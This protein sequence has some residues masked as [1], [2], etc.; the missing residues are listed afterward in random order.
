MDGLRQRLMMTTPLLLSTATR[1]HHATRHSPGNTLHVVAGRRS[2]TTAERVP[3]AICLNPGLVFY[4]WLRSIDHLA[5]TWTFQPELDKASLSHQVPTTA[6]YGSLISHD[7]AADSS[8]RYYPDIIGGGGDTISSFADMIADYSTDDLFE[9]AWEQG[10][11]GGSGGASGSTTAAAAMM[12]QPAASHLWSPPAPPWSDDYPPSESEMAAWLRAIVNGEELA[13]DD[14]LKTTV[15]G[16]GDRPDVAAVAK[17]STETWATEEKEKLIP[18]MEGMMGSG[19]IR[20]NKINEK[21]RTLQQLVPGCDDKTIQYLKSLKHHVQAMSV[22]PSPVAPA[23]GMPMPPAAPMVFAPAAPAMVPFGA[24]LHL[25]GGQGGPRRRPCILRRLLRER[26]RRRL[27]VPG[28]R[29]PAIEK[30]RAAAAKEREVAGACGTKNTEL[31]STSNTTRAASPLPL[32]R[33]PR[34][35]LLFVHAVHADW[36]WFQGGGLNARSREVARRFY[37]SLRLD[38]YS[39]WCYYPDVN[40]GDISSFSDLIPNYSTYVVRPDDIF[41]LASWEEQGGKTEASTTTMQPLWSPPPPDVIRSGPPSEVEMASWLC[42]IV[43][44]DEELVAVNDDDGGGGHQLAAAAGR[45]AAEERPPSDTSTTT[46]TTTWGK[47]EKLPTMGSTKERR[48]HKINERFR[49]LQQLV[50]GCDDKAATLD[51]TIQ[52]MKSLQQHVQAMSDG[53]PTAAAVYPGV[54]P[55]VA[56][57]AMPMPAAAPAMVMVVPLGGAMLQLPHYPAPA[58]PLMTTPG[59]G[60][61]SSSSGGHRHGS[62]SSKGNKGG[63][64]RSLRHKH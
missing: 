34:R 9:L 51:K 19:K 61:G 8:G 32:A 59:G 36:L 7:D 48:R 44:G 6:I 5:S 54:P 42:A 55:P 52:Y 28:R 15:A 56:P 13:F 45:D 22:V 1:Q 41:E 35:L 57:V 53:A 33:A 46:A 60:V 2:K 21:L 39:P 37:R 10:G 4:L 50:P 17:G 49:T 16:G 43:R 26:R 3:T 40:A 63:S 31:A 58:V 25:P 29:R 30:A 18:V 23:I 64:I 47:T 20:R 14:E 27:E 62:S 38:R 11:G 12:L 24:M